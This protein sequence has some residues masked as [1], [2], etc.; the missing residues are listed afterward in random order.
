MFSEAK[1]M[2]W[3]YVEGIAVGLDTVGDDLLEYF[4]DD[5]LERDGT[6]GGWIMDRFVFFVYHDNFRLFPGGWYVG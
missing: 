2:R 5:I 4:A 1:L 3:D 6:I